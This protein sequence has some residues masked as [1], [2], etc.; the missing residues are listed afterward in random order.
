MRILLSKI[1]RVR[2]EKKS[3]HAIWQSEQVQVREKL[4][5]MHWQLSKLNS[6]LLCKLICMD[7]FCK[8]KTESK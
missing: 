2:N 3:V 5:T 6:K 8:K 4:G 1:W 7:M